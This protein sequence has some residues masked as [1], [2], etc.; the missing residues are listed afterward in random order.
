MGEWFPADKRN[1]HGT[2]V[3]NLTNPFFKIVKAGMW[4]AIIVLGAIGTIEVT[5]VRH[6]KAAL[7]R[8]PVEETPA[9]FQNVVTGKL[10]ADFT[11]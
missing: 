11:G 6:I 10:A 4:P 5:T 9:R 8:F 3:A 2:K 1:A 7:Q